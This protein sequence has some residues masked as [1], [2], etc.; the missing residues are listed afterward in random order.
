MLS[1]K[2]GKKA[3]LFAKCRPLALKTPN[4]LIYRHVPESGGFDAVRSLAI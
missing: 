3:P 4:P 2:G 1:T